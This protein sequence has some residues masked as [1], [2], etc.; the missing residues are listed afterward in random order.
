MLVSSRTA[1]SGLRDASL[2]AWFRRLKPVARSRNGVESE[3]ICCQSGPDQE[4]P[5]RVQS[6]MRVGIRCHHA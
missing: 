2:R 4:P 1:G 6:S 3:E 5:F